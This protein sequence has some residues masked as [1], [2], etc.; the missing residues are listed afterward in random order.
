MAQV[1]PEGWYADPQD[2][3]PGAERWW[4]GYLSR[5]W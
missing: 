1:V 5:G 2:A 3:T 4:N